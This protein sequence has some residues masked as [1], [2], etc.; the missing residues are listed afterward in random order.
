MEEKTKPKKSSANSYA[1]YSSLAFQLVL[2]VVL[3]TWLGKKADDYFQ[4]QPFIT[5]AAAL[6]STVGG[7]Y[8]FFKRISNL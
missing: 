4:T 3:G 5:I 8:I 2:T 7:L 6:I 1:I